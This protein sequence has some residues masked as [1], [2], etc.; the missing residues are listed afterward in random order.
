MLRLHSPHDSFLSLLFLSHSPQLQSDYKK[1]NVEIQDRCQNLE[2]ICNF[3]VVFCIYAHITKESI[4]R[5]SL[6]WCAMRD[7]N[8]HGR[9]PEPKSGA[10]ANSANR[11]KCFKNK[12]MV[13]PRGIEPRLPPWKGGVLTAWPW[14][15]IICEPAT[16]CFPGQSPT[17]YHR[18]WRA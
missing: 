3:L 8:P 16:S 1:R 6:P 2:L 14:S 11:A 15:H 13:T 7:L 18:R 9:P 12:K 17:K 4:F 5:Y 10:S